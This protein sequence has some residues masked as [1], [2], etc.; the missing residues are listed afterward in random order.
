V[1]VRPGVRVAVARREQLG[2]RERELELLAARRAVRLRLQQTA[3]S[4]RA[5]LE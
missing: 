2:D 1:P 4:V 5:Q 3:E